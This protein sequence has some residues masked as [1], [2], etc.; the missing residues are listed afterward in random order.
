MNITTNKGTSSM[1]H[2]WVDKNP[3][4]NLIWQ[5]YDQADT[6]DVWVAMD[7][8]DSGS[9]SEKLPWATPKGQAEQGEQ[10]VTSSIWKTRSEG[11]HH[12]CLIFDTKVTPSALPADLALTKLAAT[13][14]GMNFPA[15]DR[16]GLDVAPH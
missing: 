16:V 8:D 12:A 15:L 14:G 6:E 4:T 7:S 11:M 13:G 9:F 10:L 2:M 3:P 1:A 5:P